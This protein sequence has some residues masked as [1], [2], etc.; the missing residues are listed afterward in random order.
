MIDAQLLKIL[1][2]PETRQELAVAPDSVVAL[3]NERIVSGELTNRGGQLVT[4]RLD[5][6]LIRKDGTFLYPV[7]QN[8]PVMLI[9]EAVAL[10]PL[11]KT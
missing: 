10:Q 2:C 8:I 5:G 3:L 1:C 11:F 6:G 4:V 7:R 9:E